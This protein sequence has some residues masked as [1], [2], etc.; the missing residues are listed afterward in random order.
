M[1][2]QEYRKSLNQKLSERVKQEL[3]DFHEGILSKTPQEIYDAAHQIILKSN[4]AE[5]FLETD[6]SP[7]AAKAL[8]KSPNLLQ[9]IYEECLEKDNSHKEDL[10]QIIKDFK[11]YMVKTEKILSEKE[12]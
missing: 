7:Q 1:H 2:Y 4:I 9:D 8:M 11:D 6:Y 10:H 3:S 5:Y 12:R